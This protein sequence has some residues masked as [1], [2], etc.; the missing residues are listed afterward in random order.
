MPDEF[1]WVVGRLKNLESTIEC[2]T[3]MEKLTEEKVNAIAEWIKKKALM[4]E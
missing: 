4:Q 1:W 3:L 2:L